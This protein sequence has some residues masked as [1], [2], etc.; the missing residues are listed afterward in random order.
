MDLISLF[1]LRIGE[2]SYCVR[3][4]YSKRK[5]VIQTKKRHEGWTF[6][7]PPARQ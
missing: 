5:K 2:V 6:D 4:D 7:E 3:I 1:A